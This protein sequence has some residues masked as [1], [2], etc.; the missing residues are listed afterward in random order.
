M[1]FTTNSGFTLRSIWTSLSAEARGGTYLNSVQIRPLQ[2]LYSR[3]HVLDLVFQVL[4]TVRVACASWYR[5]R[6]EVLNRLRVLGW[7]L[8]P[9]I[10]K[11]EV[12]DSFHRLW[13]CRIAQARLTGFAY[14]F[15]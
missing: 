4:I 5:S 14:A 13:Q 6:E 11:D 7:V 2:L 9:L 10:G 1:L 8:Q 15:L 3:V 12:L